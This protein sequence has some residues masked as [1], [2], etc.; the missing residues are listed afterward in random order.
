MKRRLA[1]HGRS[2]DVNMRAEVVPLDLRFPYASQFAI[3]DCT[4]Q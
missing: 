1:T 3:H 2:D 4:V